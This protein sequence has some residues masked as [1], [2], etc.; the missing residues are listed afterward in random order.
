MHNLCR[1][2]PFVALLLSVSNSPADPLARQSNDSKLPFGSISGRV[3]LNGKPV[4]RVPVILTQ[5]AFEG[6]VKPVAKTTTD[7]DGRFR[8]TNVPAGSFNLSA[9]APAFVFDGAT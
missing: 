3:T 8:I 9:F 1:L 7:Q 4:P 6:D 5:N 2:L